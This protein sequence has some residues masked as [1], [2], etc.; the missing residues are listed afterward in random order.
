MKIAATLLMFLVLL[1]PNALAQDYTRVNLPEGAIARLGKG[2]VR[3]VQY[4]P[5]GARL[6][7]LSAIGIWLYDTTTHREVALLAGHTERV[8][9]V[10]FSPDGRTLASGSKDKT[11]CLWDTATWE[12]KQTLTGHSSWVDMVAFSPDGK[13]L[14]AGN[15]VTAVRLWKIAD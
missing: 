12:L 2:Y 6:A 1:L 13:T 15:R 3:E 14:A 11:V 9:S 8:V 5:D 10:A 7:V 4:S